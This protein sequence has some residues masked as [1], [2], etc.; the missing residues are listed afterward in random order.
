LKIFKKSIVLSPA[1]YDG[2]S[3][4]KGILTLQEKAGELVGTLKCF[5]IEHLEGK[6]LLGLSFDNNKLHKFSIEKG[7]TQHFNFSLP[8][9]E[10]LQAN[11]ACVVV[12]INNSDHTPVIWGS[13]KTNLDWKSNVLENFVNKNTKTTS[14]NMGNSQAL[15]TKDETS[16]S[17][18]KQQVEK[19]DYKKTDD[20]KVK[21]EDSEEQ[22]QEKDN[23][24]DKETK[25]LIDSQ[26]KKAEEQLKAEE[27]QKEQEIKSKASKESSNKK[28]YR[29]DNTS[30]KEQKK[31]S[32]TNRPY[33]HLLKMQNID[34]NN[35]SSKKLLQEED[36][37]LDD[38][39]EKTEPKNYEGDMFYNEV[40]EQINS[41]F[42]KYPKEEALEEI[43]P[44]SKFV[45]V[46]FDADTDVYIF[47]VVYDEDNNAEYIV[48][49]IPSVYEAEPPEQFDGY[50]QWLPL[51]LEK[52]EEDGY[53]LMYQDAKTGDHIRV[54]II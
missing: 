44:N 42:E 28:A 6:M 54:E 12:N 43:I 5:N 29:E 8:N 13:S 24:I 11:I 7:K 27:Q 49:G 2:K 1:S 39:K 17:N 32:S 52:P 4:E 47:G 23:Y 14:A 19:R 34:E 26:V 30:V 38:L 25:E 36:S 33:K 16:N 20:I 48:Y 37:N 35:A 40:K 50:Y 53:W 31:F 15:K 46:E 21:N 10:D 45:R 51:D 9:S 3:E 41:L 18:E 22:K